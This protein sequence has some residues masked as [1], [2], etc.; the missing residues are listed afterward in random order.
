MELYVPLVKRGTKPTGFLY[1]FD[2]YFFVMEGRNT[3]RA[4]L[5]IPRR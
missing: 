5:M 1:C 4:N 2:I 3:K